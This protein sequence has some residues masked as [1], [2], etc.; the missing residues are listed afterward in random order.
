M[1]QF[2]KN[3]DLRR[4]LSLGFVLGCVVGLLGRQLS[5]GDT[6]DFR[7]LHPELAA[8]DVIDTVLYDPE[9]GQLYVCYDDANQVDVY[10]ENGSFL[11]AVAT[12]YIRNTDFLLRD[13]NLILYGNG[14]AYIYRAGDG[15]FVENRNTDGMALPPAQADQCPESLAFSA[16]RVWRILEDGGKQL[17][18]SRPWWHRIFDFML[19]WCISMACAAGM[20][21]LSLM[22]KAKAWKGIQ[23]ELQFSANR[24]RRLH[25]YY[26][27]G[28]VVL[29]S[30]IVLEFLLA[31]WGVCPIFILFPVTGCFVL[32]SILADSFLGR[33]SLLDEEEKAIYFWRACYVGAYILLFAASIGALLLWAGLRQ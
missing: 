8:P 3:M 19:S 5:H 29:L 10:T 17:L 21:V 7:E 31:V 12:P 16:Y 18:V 20:G 6:R 33:T 26:R 11:W 1:R 22:E 15:T 9:L 4:W 32:A 2:M 24:S 28:A 30:M 13:G 23:S 27:C 25:N 14:D